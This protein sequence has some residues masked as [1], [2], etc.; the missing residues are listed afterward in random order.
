M[1]YYVLLCLPPTEGNI[2]TKRARLGLFIV[3]F[4]LSLNWIYSFTLDLF[5][6][7]SGV[8]AYS[9][10]DIWDKNMLCLQFFWGGK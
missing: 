10:W 5:D 4:T 3:A 6:A 9:R 8:L 2:L 7:S 1:L